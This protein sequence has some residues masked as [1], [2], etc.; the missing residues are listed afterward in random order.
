MVLVDWFYVCN[1]FSVKQ[2]LLKPEC[3]LFSMFAMNGLKCIQLQ[4]QTSPSARASN[5]S[6]SSS[7]SSLSYFI[8]ATSPLLPK[9]ASFTTMTKPMSSQWLLQLVL[10]LLLTLASIPRPSG[11]CWSR[12]MNSRDWIHTRTTSFP[13]GGGPAADDGP[14]AVQDRHIV[15]RTGRVRIF[16]GFNSV[17]KVWRLIICF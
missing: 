9:A 10:S 4:Q 12:S 2:H 16:H 5:A 1:H 3:S 6:S 14:F 7:S 17:A 13:S 8:E 15:D 11:S